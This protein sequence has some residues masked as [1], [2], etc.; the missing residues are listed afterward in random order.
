MGLDI[1][2]N[3]H[4]N[5]FIMEI[6]NSIESKYILVDWDRPHGHERLSPKPITM[7]KNEAHKLNRAL[8]INKQSRRYIKSE[9]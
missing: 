6:D 7:T 8:L 3:N 5:T 4:Y 1:G 2:G 9:V